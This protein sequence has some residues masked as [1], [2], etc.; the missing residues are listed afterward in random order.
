LMNEWIDRAPAVLQTFYSGMEGGRAL[1]KLLFGDESPSG[2]L[3]FTVPGSANDLPFFDKNAT[4]IEY[5]PYHG[6][7]L[8]EESGW[9]A[10][11]AFG[12]GLSYSSFAYRAFKVRRTRDAIEADVSIANVGGVE[13][14]EIAQLYVGFP[15][16]IVDR[17]KKLL[18]GF[19]RVRL[20]PGEIRTIRFSVPVESLRYYDAVRRIWR[21]EPGT[22]LVSVG[23][24][25]SEQDLIRREVAI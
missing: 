10:A 5:G 19:E 20:K 7:T 11:F 12:F 25:S 3:P 22:H 17:P 21:V 14:G 18:R 15:G 23:G 1:A 24:S 2:K 8:M 4:T 6:Y 9:P 13:A 16:R